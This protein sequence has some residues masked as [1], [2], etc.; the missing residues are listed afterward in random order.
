[1]TMLFEQW[2][3]LDGGWLRWSAKNHAQLA[4]QTGTFIG[5]WEMW[6]A[7]DITATVI[8]RQQ[9]FSQAEILP[10][11]EEWAAV[12]VQM[13]P[14]AGFSGRGKLIVQLGTDLADVAYD[15]TALSPSAS[16]APT[17][18][19]G[20]ATLMFDQRPAQSSGQLQWSA[21]NTGELALQ[22]GTPIG[23]WEIVDTDNITTTIVQRQVVY[24]TEEI[25]PNAVAWTPR[26]DLAPLTSVQGWYTIVVQLGTDIAS[27]DY[28]IGTDGRVVE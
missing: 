14:S 17:Q 15:W 28:L 10:G 8:P 16:A 24:A 19:A 23:E 3:Y 6:D 1:M 5:E 27:V 21:K 2:P 13:A 22:V 11:A 25:L 12:W 18:H 26:I 4:E 7:D 20:V 9:V